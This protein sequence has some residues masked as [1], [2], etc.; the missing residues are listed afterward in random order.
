MN[1]GIDLQNDILT[2]LICLDFLYQG[3]QEFVDA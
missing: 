2:Y 1:N 3:I